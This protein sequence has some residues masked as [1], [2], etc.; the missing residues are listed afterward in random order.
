LTSMSDACER[1]LKNVNR[2]V[3]KQSEEMHIG[4]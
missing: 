1:W 3:E 2:F 4:S